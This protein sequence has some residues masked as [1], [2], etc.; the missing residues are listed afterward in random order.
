M[1]DTISARAMSGRILTMGHY[2]RPGL[3]LQSDADGKYVTQNNLKRLGSRISSFATRGVIIDAVKVFQA[4]GKLKTNPPAR[5]PVSRR[6]RY[7]RGGFCR[8]G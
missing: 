1:E 8:P 2:R 5:P 6:H 7:Y 4:A 3:L